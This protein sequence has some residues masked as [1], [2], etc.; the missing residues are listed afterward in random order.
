MKAIYHRT[1]IL[2]VVVEDDGGNVLLEPLNGTEDERFWVGFDDPCLTLD[3]TD[4]EMD[5]LQPP[6]VVGA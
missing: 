5:A 1:S 3:P 4:G 6:P 2:C